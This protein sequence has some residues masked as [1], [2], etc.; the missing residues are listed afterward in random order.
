MSSKDDIKIVNGL[1]CNVHETGDQQC[2]VVEY[3]KQCPHGVRNRK[4]GYCSKHY[5]RFQRTGTPYLVLPSGGSLPR[6]ER[7]KFKEMREKARRDQGLSLMCFCAHSYSE[8]GNGDGCG[9][10]NC[11][12]SRFDAT[13]ATTF[14]E[15][16]AKMKRLGFGDPLNDLA[17][18]IRCKNYIRIGHWHDQTCIVRIREHL[19]V[20]VVAD[21][22]RRAG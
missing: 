13:N 3:N 2:S 17:M 9:H 5:A 16:L 19:R 21:R 12:C 18:C 1:I 20:H 6:S 14:Y 15:V 10:R 11:K 4:R 22:N 7:Q 8:H